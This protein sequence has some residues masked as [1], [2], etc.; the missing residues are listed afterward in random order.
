MIDELFAEHFV[1]WL[2]KEKKVSVEMCG[3][4]GEWLTEYLKLS[5]V[6]E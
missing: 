4:I 6:E 1:E 5:V 3:D 2:F